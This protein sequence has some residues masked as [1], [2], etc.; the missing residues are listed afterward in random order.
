MKKWKRYGQLY[1]RLQMQN[2]RSLAQYRADF[3]MMIFFTLLSQGCALAMVGM[4]YSNIPAVGGWTMWEILMLYGFLLFSEGSVNFFFQGAWKI[5]NMIRESEL[6]RFLV[7]P[8]PAGLQILTAKIDFEGL[9]KMA[10]ASALLILSVR[11][12]ET[13]FCPLKYM[14]MAVF[15]V[16]ACLIRLCMVWT[17]S[18]ASFWMENGRNSLNFF[19]ISLGEL[20][21][22]PLVIYPPVLKGIFGYLIPYA[23]VSYY[24]AGFLLGK[25]GMELGAACMPLVCAGM[26]AVSWIVFKRG[27]LR[28]E[29]SSQN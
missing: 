24:P 17:A 29:S 19:V 16:Q 10:I 20:A 14:L 12:C 11:H 23:F 25:D 18:C 1:V 5:A 6:D 2:I 27:L 7:R 28:Y 3:L 22:Y 15:V 4:I 21:K 9:N 13:A 8:L 26:T